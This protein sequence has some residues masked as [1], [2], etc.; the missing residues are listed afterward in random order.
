M[1]YWRGSLML[2]DFRQEFFP[3]F[4]LVAVNPYLDQL[5]TVKADSDLL[6]YGFGK[7]LLAD[8]NDGLQG[9]GPGAKR[10]SLGGCDIKHRQEPSKARILQGLIQ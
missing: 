9:V 7:P 5:V 3:F 8:R 2:A 1:L 10:A 6:H 4:S